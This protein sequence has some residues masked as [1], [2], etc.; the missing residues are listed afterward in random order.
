MP[1]GSGPRICPGRTLAMV[2]MRL[3]LATLYKSFAVE[4]AGDVREAFALT[5]MPRG[6]TVRL[7]RR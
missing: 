6:M 7:A 2:E 1:F 3:A 4:R 5:M